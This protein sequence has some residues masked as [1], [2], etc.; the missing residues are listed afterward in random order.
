MG[1]HDNTKQSRKVPTTVTCAQPDFKDAIRKATV[2]I[3]FKDN[4]K[5]TKYYALQLRDCNSYLKNEFPLE[6]RH[7]ARLIC[8]N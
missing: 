1:R 4:G 6:W 2:R 7:N 3:F 8:H 5:A